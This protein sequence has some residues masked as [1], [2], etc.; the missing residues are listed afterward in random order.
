MTFSSFEIQQHFKQTGYLGLI[1][2]Y[3][4]DVYQFLHLSI[5]EFL[6]AWWIAKY[7]EKTEEIFNAHFDDDHSKM[8]LTFV[9]GLTQLKHE[10]YQQ[11][12]NKE[13]DLQCKRRPLFGFDFC[14]HS[15]FYQNP[16]IGVNKIRNDHIAIDDND[17]K[18][19]VLLQLLYESQNEILCQIF[20]DL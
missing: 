19:D 11:Y 2:N 12:F 17:C 5:Q 14:Y 20:Y 8:C 18:F 7:N 3:D 1:R 9:A 16:E 4:K 10:N 15:R 6:A 13:L